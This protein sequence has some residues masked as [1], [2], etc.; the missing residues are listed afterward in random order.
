MT[1]RA[2]RL[3]LDSDKYSVALDTLDNTSMLNCVS[4]DLVRFTR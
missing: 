4:H 1:S 2:C 3:L